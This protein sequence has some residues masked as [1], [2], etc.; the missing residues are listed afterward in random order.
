MKTLERYLRECYANN[1]IDHAIRAEVR[2]TGEVTFYVHPAATGGDTLDFIVDGNRLRQSPFV[3]REGDEP[4]KSGDD[5]LDD[6]TDTIVGLAVDAIG[7]FGQSFDGSGL[8]VQIRRL[9]LDNC[10]E[11]WEESAAESDCRKLESSLAAAQAEVKR[12]KAIGNSMCNELGA[13]CRDLADSFREQLQ[14][15][16]DAGGK[17]EQ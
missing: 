8:A 1:V 17:E 4:E 12:L 5:K 13:F 9:L 11:L 6:V 2:S 16:A 3:T 14:K 15:P 7:D 10:S